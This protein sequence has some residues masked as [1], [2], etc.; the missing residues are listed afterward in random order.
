M[1]LSP[2]EY[3]LTMDKDG[4]ANA[5]NLKYNREDLHMDGEPSRVYLEMLATYILYIGSVDPNEKLAEVF[6]VARE[7]FNANEMSDNLL[8]FLAD[9]CK[10]DPA[11]ED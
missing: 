8:R 7:R 4:L 11:R 6:K 9:S 3:G 1:F 5:L 10:P 2:M